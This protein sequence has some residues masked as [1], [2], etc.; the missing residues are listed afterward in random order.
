[1]NR[2]TDSLFLLE[3]LVERRSKSLHPRGGRV[4]F[5]GCNHVLVSLKIMRHHHHQHLTE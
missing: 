2:P 3:E 5:M 4:R 1:M